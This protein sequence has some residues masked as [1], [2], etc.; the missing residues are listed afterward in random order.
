[1]KHPFSQ[2]ISVACALFF[3]GVPSAYSSSDS[4]ILALKRT[5]ADLVLTLEAEL[6]HAGLEQI[7]TA[8]K[9]VQRALDETSALQSTQE[10]GMSYDVDGSEIVLDTEDSVSP[11]PAVSCAMVKVRMN[12][13]R[14]EIKL[15]TSLIHQLMALIDHGSIPDSVMALILGQVKSL[16]KRIEDTYPAAWDE[17]SLV[18]TRHWQKLAPSS[19]LDDEHCNE[20]N[21]TH[22]PI[23][24][25]PWTAMEPISI[26]WQGLE[27][28]PGNLPQ[29]LTFSA[30]PETVDIIEQ[31]SVTTFCL[32]P[33]QLQMRAR[34]MPAPSASPLAPP[35]PKTE[36][37]FRSRKGRS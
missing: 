25:Q 14:V 13:A 37:V 36:F 8:A 3:W 7:D 30:G 15:L 1:M 29:A 11:E 6:S 20:I 19:H 35:L 23:S 5:A 9:A 10:L 2:L 31:A 18:I 33:R 26:L 17:K 34:L 21:L 4:P 28:S 16:S 12:E 32:E 27:W 24:M 22:L